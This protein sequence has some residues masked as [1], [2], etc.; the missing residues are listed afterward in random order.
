MLLILLLS[1]LVV[2]G[3]LQNTN[4]SAINYATLDDLVQQY[5]DQRYED[6]QYEDQ[7]VY[8][9]LYDEPQR[10]GKYAELNEDADEP[11]YFYKPREGD[12]GDYDS[13]EGWG[14]Y[15][16]SG[17]GEIGSDGISDENR[18]DKAEESCDQDSKCEKEIEK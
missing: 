7:Q 4:T 15:V 13:L 6:Q 11:R 2:R 14:D 12:E 5:E 1:S 9:P 17:D 16:H 10:D 3:W 18:E 8:E